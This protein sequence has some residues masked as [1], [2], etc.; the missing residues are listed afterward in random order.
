M[1]E[2]ATFIAINVKPGAMAPASTALAATIMTDAQT[3]GRYAPGT[4]HL[5]IGQSV[6]FKNVSDAVHTVTADS[7][8]FDSGNI[9]VGATWRFTAT[10]AGTFR[11]HCTY[12]P[13][14][15]GTVIVSG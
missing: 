5:R 9:A 11:Y 14:M 12:H 3:V 1:P 7:G 4:L 6:V 13:L 10:K 8:A 15:H 2:A